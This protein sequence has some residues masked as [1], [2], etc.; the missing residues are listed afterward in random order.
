M[1]LITK[2]RDQFR[3]YLCV[4]NG[5][6]DHALFRAF[7]ETDY[8]VKTLSSYQ[9]L[10]FQLKSE[11][12]H[13]LLLFYKPLNVSFQTL[14]E[15][16]KG[17]S[18]ETQVVL[19][20]TPEYWPGIKARIQQG[21]A[22]TYWPWPGTEIEVLHYNLDCILEKLAYKYMAEQKGPLGQQLVE[23]IEGLELQLVQQ[24][25]PSPQI[26]VRALPSSVESESQ[27]V[28]HLMTHFKNSF[29]ESEFAFLKN[30]QPR[31]QVLVYKTSFSLQN[32][33]R[34]QAF[35]YPQEVARKDRDQNFSEL[36]ARVTDLFIS[37]DFVIYPVQS[38]SQV[39]GFF[40]GFQLSSEAQ[41]ELESGVNFM[42]LLLRNLN[43]EKA[44]SSP[45]S[46]PL[47]ER[48]VDSSQLVHL[49]S[50]EIS[51][52][53]R[54]HSP[55]S[56]IYVHARSGEDPDSTGL[57][58]LS[59]VENHLRVY[60]FTSQISRQESLI[61]LPHC[62]S[63]N[64]AIKAERLRRL[65]F[66]LMEKQGQENFRIGLGV[67]SFPE[68]SSGPDELIESAKASC[69]QVLEAGM[70][71]VCLYTQEDHFQAEYQVAPGR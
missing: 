21:V 10:V 66:R 13:V 64:A 61:L 68:L 55:L 23:R 58:F 18:P 53:R 63:E 67:S 47:L 26:S 27:L 41:S 20:G 65:F 34:G 5:D 54:T 49:V 46:H 37:N 29:P 9:D 56:C 35:D 3:I 6:G 31:E 70:N 38:P 11:R 16:V 32:I 45:K 69:Y 4:E 42:G 60:D 17:L 62:S 44:L 57:N 48:T 39:Y 15:K 50:R 36:K 51:R 14:L 40:V 52:S 28:E 59:I 12:P 2:I 33:A 8:S 30:Y 19:L 71:K 24:E 43:L 25:N 1:S 22:Q 7:Q